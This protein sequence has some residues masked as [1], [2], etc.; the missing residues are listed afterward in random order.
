ME[1]TLKISK[2]REGTV[3]DHIPAGKAIK[4]LAILKIDEKGSQT[5]SVG[6]RVPS[7]RNSYIV[8]A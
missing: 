3:I 4:V 1:Q 5:V 7:G 8:L 6:I 2:I